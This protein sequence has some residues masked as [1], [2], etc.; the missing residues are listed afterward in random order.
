[1]NTLELEVKRDKLRLH[2]FLKNRP[3]SDVA[4]ED[5]DQ[6]KLRDLLT[7]SPVQYSQSINDLADINGFLRKVNSRMETGH[8]FKGYFT[9]CKVLSENNRL[10]AVPVLGK[11]AKTG[12]FLLHR[13]IPKTIGVKSV[14]FFFTKGRNRRLSKAEVLGRL[15][16][17]GFEI[18][19]L[20]QKDG[21]T[22]F[23]VRKVSEPLQASTVSEGWIYRMPR[24]GRNGKMI[25][26]YKFRTMHPYSEFLQDYL[27]KT[28]GYGNNGKIA[29]DFRM[30]SWGKIMRRYWLDEVPQLINVIKGDMKLVGV[31]PISMSYFRDIPEDLQQ[32]R[33]RHK[34]GCIPPYV[35]MNRASS[36]SSVLKA[37]REYLE[38]CTRNPYTTD[39]KY[40]F[41]AI[42]NI[43]VKK[44]RSA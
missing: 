7:P 24:V 26:V 1:M 44:K 16:Y 31:R 17:C 2:Y 13:V 6:L 32:L 20:E 15:L 18:I 43:I 39:A 30:T 23:T 14:Y 40:L 25:H 10:F 22:H 8:L 41:W 35:A 5:A 21:I 11:I 33:T 9:D 42:Y 4:F 34:P 12:D 28:N 3:K 38:T 27:R 36:V 37:E 29:N 19:E